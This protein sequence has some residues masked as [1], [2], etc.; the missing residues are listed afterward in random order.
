MKKIFINRLAAIMFCMAVSGCVTSSSESDNV[1]LPGFNV[2]E[3]KAEIRE[4]TIQFTAAHI[5]KDTAFLNDIFTAGATIYPPNAEA[6]TGLA[7]IAQLNWD[8]VNYGIHEFDEVSG[9]IYGNGEYI[10]DEGTYFLRYG[11]EDITDQG[12]YINIWKKDNGEWRIISNIWNTSLPVQTSDENI[13][14]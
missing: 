9:K 14:I 11:E 4:K 8:W 7:A 6:V 2:E 1:P 13:D 12:K 5:S 10:I 3:A